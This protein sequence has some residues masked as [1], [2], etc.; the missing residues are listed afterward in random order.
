VTDD[1]FEDLIMA[2]W[3]NHSTPEEVMEEFEFYEAAHKIRAQLIATAA[4]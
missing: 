2:L 4:P 1:E 3:D